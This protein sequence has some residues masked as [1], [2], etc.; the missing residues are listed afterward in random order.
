M[1]HKEAAQG[2][3]SKRQSPAADETQRFEQTVR[4]M[5]NTPP[6]P[7]AE[8]AKKEGGRSRPKLPSKSSG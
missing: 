7:H 8:V 2:R 4:R 6:K 5:L 3:P 1:Q